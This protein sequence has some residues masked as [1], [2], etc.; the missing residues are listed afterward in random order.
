[1]R[2]GEGCFHNLTKEDFT[3]PR[4]ETRDTLIFFYQI[5]IM[6]RNLLLEELV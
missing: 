6:L 4:E 2:S 5:Y 3:L 1:M